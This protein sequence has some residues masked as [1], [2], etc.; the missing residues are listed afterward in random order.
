MRKI[1]PNN[2]LPITGACPHTDHEG[3]TITMARVNAAREESVQVTM[4]PAHREFFEILAQLS[5]QALSAAFAAMIVTIGL[6]EYRRTRQ[7]PP[8][9]LAD[10]LEKL[11]EEI[12]RTPEYLIAT[13]A[14]M[15]R[16]RDRMAKRKAKPAQRENGP[17]SDV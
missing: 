8:E 6:K 15:R 11:K 4:S 16:K 2:T 7:V 17:E 10:V 3:R 1:A 14:V 12:S 5:T 9:T 13:E